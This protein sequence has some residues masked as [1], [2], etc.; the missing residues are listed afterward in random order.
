[1]TT[2]ILGQ[3]RVYCLSARFDSTLMWSHYAN[4]HRGVC[5]EFR[6]DNEVFGPAMKVNYADDYPVFDFTSDDPLVL[7]ITKASAWS[8]E[9]EYRVVALEKFIDPAVAIAG[10]IRTKDDFLKLPPGALQS[11]IMGCMIVKSDADKLQEI[12][13]KQFP[14]HVALKRAVRVPNRYSLSIETC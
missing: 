11:V 2:A 3:S 14:R 9:E 4:N 6:C 7:L 5:L 10:V 13:G 1:M 12:I 8:Y